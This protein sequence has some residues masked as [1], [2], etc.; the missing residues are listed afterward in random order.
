MDAK[1]VLAEADR[2]REK[3]TDLE[4]RSRRNN[5]RIFGVMEGTEG[6][7]VAKYMEHL[8]KTELELPEGTNL[9]IQRAH[10][11]LAPKPGPGAAPRSIVANFLQFEMKETVLKKAWQKK[12]QVGGKPVFFDHDY[13]AEIVQKRKTYVGIKKVLKEKGIRFQTPLT[14]I[15]I[16][17]NNGV[18]TYGSAR[19]AARDMEE[20]G[21][22]VDM[23]GRD[24]E[25]AAGGRMQREPEWQRVTGQS[26]SRDTAH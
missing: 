12:M 20:R 9:Q 21:Y 8:L 26:R 15:R 10:R 13:R 1:D 11:A 19:E 24:T 25:L 14:K 4:G 23:P 18:R 22:T 2:L 7:S 5:I 16:H 3:V 17:W 6:T